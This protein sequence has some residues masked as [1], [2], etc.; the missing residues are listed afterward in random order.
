MHSFFWWHKNLFWR[1]VWDWWSFL[2]LLFVFLFYYHLAHLPRVEDWLLF[3]FSCCF[4]L[5]D[6][7][8]AGRLAMCGGASHVY[9][10]SPTWRFLLPDFDFSGMFNTFERLLDDRGKLLVRFDKAESLFPP[11]IAS[12]SLAG[13]VG[14]RKARK[15]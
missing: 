10:I 6:L 8:K 12:I 11:D 14:G 2:M 13:M 4:L 5:T 15:W 9:K 7:A 3:V 1:F